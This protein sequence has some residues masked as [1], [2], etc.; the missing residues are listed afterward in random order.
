MRWSKW[1]IFPIFGIPVGVALIAGALIVK[2]ISSIPP[3]FDIEQ[4][5]ENKY[6]ALVL[7]GTGA[8]GKALIKTLEE[9]RGCQEI[10]LL[11][12]RKPT[13]PLSSKVV[14]HEIDMDTMSQHP[15][16][17]K[18]VDKIFCCLGSR[19]QFGEATLRKVD[20]DYAVT[21]AKLGKANG[22]KYFGY[23]SSLG[24][25]PNA[26]VLYPR[27]KG[28]GEEAVKR[29]GMARTVIFR[30]SLL[31]TDREEKEPR[32]G[33]YIAQLIFPRV[34]WLLLGGLRK[35]RSITVDEV[36]QGIIV[37]AE[38]KPKY[39]SSRPMAE[40]YESNVIQKM[41]KEWREAKKTQLTRDLWRRA[42]EAVDQ[43]DGPHQVWVDKGKVKAKDSKTQ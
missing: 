35:Y 26:S 23:E 17:F 14:S 2:P 24:A 4:A 8:T 15:E 38:S 29:V 30:P 10:V 9:S 21:A 13:I 34:D 42:Q 40:L 3:P 6:R 31:L 25:S 12:R 18:G 20:I 7:G 11:G 37:N 19:T 27:V 16:L 32:W 1:S 43:Q 33:E 41:A 28:E 5:E 22:A 39:P 36:A